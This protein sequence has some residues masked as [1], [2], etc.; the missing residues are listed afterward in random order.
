MFTWPL[1]PRLPEAR[2]DRFADRLVTRLRELFTEFAKVGRQTQCPPTFRAVKDA[3]QTVTSTSLTQV[4]FATTQWDTHG[5]WVAASNRYLPLDFSGYYRV[6]A[7]ISFAPQAVSAP[8][9][10]CAIFKNGS[11]YS[12]VVIPQT[13]G[14]RLVIL[15][16]DLVY[17]NG[18]TDYVE[19]WMLTAEA[20]DL[21]AEAYRC[22]VS[23]E[24]VGADQLP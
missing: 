16:T 11:E 24:Y 3:V 21:E 15:T 5:Y 8:N 2:E 7:K 10:R 20:V 1:F 14:F 19:V 9:R 22:S 6:M 18:S 23:I 4:T 13:S 12:S 17:L